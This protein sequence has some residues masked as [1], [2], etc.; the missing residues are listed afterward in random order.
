MIGR[1]QLVNHFPW[2]PECRYGDKGI[3]KATY[4]LTQSLRINVLQESKLNIPGIWA[5]KHVSLKLR[6]HVL[7]PIGRPDGLRSVPRTHSGA[8]DK[9]PVASP[10]TITHLA[11]HVWD[12]GKW[13]EDNVHLFPSHVYKCMHNMYLGWVWGYRVRVQNVFVWSMQTQVILT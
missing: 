13:E 12:K 7:E 10:R 9:C 4:L 8:E 5:N 2:K 1:T 6:D 11:P 3:P